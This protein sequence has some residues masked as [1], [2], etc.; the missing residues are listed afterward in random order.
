MFFIN[1]IFYKRV[2]QKNWLI[3]YINKRYILKFGNKIFE[4][5]I[6]NGGLKN[7][8]KKLEGD[9]STPIGKWYLV[10]LYYRSDRVQR[11]KFKQRNVLKINQISKHCGWCDDTNSHYYNKYVKINNSISKN[12]NYEKL[13]REDK[14]YDIIIVI[15]HNMKPILKNKGSAIFIHCSFNDFRNT[16]GC[17]ALKKT[18]LVFLLKNLRHHTKIKF[19]NQHKKI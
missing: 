19:Q 3:K 17:I 18:D 14:A 10:N 11:P 16:A 2:M 1:L 5:Q 15:S 8:K 12:T 7:A 4:C 6:G 9:K 13:W